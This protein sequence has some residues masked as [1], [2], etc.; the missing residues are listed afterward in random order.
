MTDF[1]DLHKQHG[2]ELVKKS[3]EN[4]FLPATTPLYP[5]QN[6]K[7]IPVSEV[8]KNLQPVSWLIE[9][10]IEQ[11]TM[12]LIFGDP[13]SGKTFFAIDMACCVATGTDW[14][15]NK[16]NKGAVF[17]IAG[18][19]HNG[20]ARRF[21]AWEQFNGVS[22]KGAPLFIA[23]RSA[24]LFDA[25][26]AKIITEAV[27]DLTDAN[28]E[29]PCLIVIDTLARNFG[30]GDENSTKDMNLF[31]QHVDALKDRWKATALIIHHTGHADKNRA[32]GAMA[33]KGALD[34][35][36]HVQKRDKNLISIQSTKT[37]EGLE[38]APLS[39]EISAVTLQH[40]DSADSIQGA[41][42]VKTG[43]QM[44]NFGKKLSPQKQRAIDILQ[45]CLIEKGE[46]R[47]ARKGMAHVNCVTI[48]EYHEAL[49]AGNLT[50]SDK[51]DS[52]SKAINRAINSLCDEGITASYGGLIWIPDKSDTSGRTR[53][54]S[55]P[56]PDGQDK[57]L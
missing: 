13:A 52:L 5:N 23:E 47:S 11:H 10:Y 41:T 38:P 27:Q 56:L 32:R 53:L 55:L 19:G 24:Q 15:G 1:N 30:G 51:P 9:G 57:S 35:E 34:H 17:Y 40:N 31:I 46:K 20:L 12:A 16:V 21:M 54:S 26:H 43:G 50:S 4:S 29:K 36:Y 49:K 33:L 22:L 14:Q 37:K 39:F 8:I 18:E 28:G 48:G 42:L 45:N 44:Q 3:V 6:Y 2:K 7:F 25:G